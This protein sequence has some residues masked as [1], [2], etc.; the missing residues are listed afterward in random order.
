MRPPVKPPQSDWHLYNIPP[1]PPWLFFGIVIAFLIVTGYHAAY[2]RGATPYY[3][4]KPPPS[5][6]VPGR[7][8]CAIHGPRGGCIKWICKRSKDAHR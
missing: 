4:G 6:S 3:A 7:C 5:A 1:P 2:G 8:W